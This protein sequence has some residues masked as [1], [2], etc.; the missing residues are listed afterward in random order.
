MFFRSFRRQESLLGCAAGVPQSDRLPRIEFN[1]PLAKQTRHAMGQ[2][3]VHVVAAHKQ[4]ITYGE[5]LQN[6]FARHLGDADEREIRGA[7]SH[8]AH[9]QL[10]A[11]LQLPAPTI[12][13]IR[14]PGVDGGLRFFQQHEGL[15][16]A[17]GQGRFMG[18]LPALASK[19]AGTVS[20]TTCS[21][22]GASGKA[23]SHAA[24]QVLQVPPRGDHRR[25]LG[26][27]GRGVPG[28]DRLMT[29]DSAMGQPGFG[30]PYRP[31]RNL[32]RLP[33]GQLANREITALPPGQ[34]KNPAPPFLF[35]P[36][37]EERGKHGPRFDRSGRNQLR[38]RQQQD[39]RLF[40]TNRRIS[41]DAIRSSQID[42][43]DI[44][45]CH[46]G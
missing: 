31:L 37:V 26:N 4:M 41:Q 34:I 45:G 25:Y 24:D 29:I 21:A 23:A 35:R 9:Q 2:R 33:P 40:F 28:E 27:F 7:A 10:I 18:Q 30:R 8:V 6:Q 43:D 20:T 3:Q 38:D 39:A 1:A 42:A 14:Q 36:Q 15:G 22:I 13:H 11:Q 16:Q 5:S 12:T 19:E 32:G 46:S 44:L 17:C